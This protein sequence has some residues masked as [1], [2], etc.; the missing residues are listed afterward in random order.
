MIRC[1]IGYDSREPVAYHV[2][3]HSIMRR[4]SWPVSIAPLSQPLLRAMEFYTRPVDEPASTEFSLTRFLVPFLSHWTE[5]TVL[6]MDADM[7]CLGDVADLVRLVPLHPMVSVCQHDYVPRAST[8][9]DGQPQVAY[10]RKNWSS[11]MA[12]HAADCRDVLTVE[13]VNSAPAAD[14]HRLAWAGD[15]V[16]ALPLAWNYLVGESSQTTEP[17]KIVHFTN[18]GPWF[19]DYRKCEYADEWRAEYQHMTGHPYGD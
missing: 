14:L 19:P 1:F 2:L 8:K 4:T 16:G 5:D 3:A 17:P 15:Q 6:F 10:P 7:L 13:Y 12:F 9:M 18:G 11:L